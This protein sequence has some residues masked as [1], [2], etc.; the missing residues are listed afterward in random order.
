MTGIKQVS[1]RTNKNFI[2]ENLKGRDQ[3]GVLDVDG[4][5]ILKLILGETSVIV[6]TGFIWLRAQ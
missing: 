2:S 5:I 4:R 1:M 3:S 6:R